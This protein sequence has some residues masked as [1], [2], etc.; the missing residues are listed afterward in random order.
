[1]KTLIFLSTLLLLCNFPSFAQT[2]NIISDTF[3]VYGNCGMCKRTIEKAANI[4]GVQSAVWNMDSDL[5]T[6][7]YDASVVDLET[8]KK[9]IASSG[10]D[11]DECRA[12]NEAYN[13][14]HGCCQYK[15]PAP[16]KSQP[17]KTS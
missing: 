16:I 5:I 1:M 17:K 2:K 7:S 9:A 8:I 14:L 4:Y 10:Y 3:R 6:V 15:R 11:T 12:T 13:K